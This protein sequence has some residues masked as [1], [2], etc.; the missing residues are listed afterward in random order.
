MEMGREG[1]IRMTLRVGIL[2]A[3][4]LLIGAPAFAGD[5]R[6][7]VAK[8]DITQP[9][10]TPLGG[11]GDRKGK[12]STGVHDPIMAKALVLDDGT[13][14]LAI[15]TTDLVGIAPEVKPKVAELAGFPAGRLLLCASHTHSGP[16]AF[17]KGAF[18]N[19]VLGKFDQKVFDSLTAGMA[20][21]ITDAEK[22]LHPAKL[23]IGE[24]EM[25]R[26][27]RNRRR[28]RIKDPKL[29]LLRV[30]TIDDKPLAALVNLTA[31]GTVLD[32][33]NMEQSADWMGFLQSYMERERPGLTALYSNGAEGDISPNIPDNSSTFDGAKAHGEIG[34]KAALALYDTL[35]PAREVKLDAKS[36]TL[37][38]P[39]SLTAALAGIGKTTELQTLT[40]NDAL[41]I[42]VPGEPITQLGLAL[43]EHARRQGFARPA[44]VGLA[45]DHLGYFLTQAEFKKGG[46]EATV[47]FFGDIFGETLTL[48]MVRLIG[49]DTAPVVAALKQEPTS[50]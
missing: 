36:S 29:W 21:A 11:Y 40:I 16:G 24:A 12:P 49:G 45:N 7:G 30:D 6:A 28:A 19:I 15:V 2:L 9:V 41:L 31:H 44:I 34:G 18:A 14:R 20:K 32:S 1:L 13:T 33:D 10:G 3:L 37:E 42:A 46:Y 26:F 25:P 38:L 43:K 8:V 22:A 27:M 48:A 39:P 4:A 35:K 50:P 23:A 47:S 17:G 5:L